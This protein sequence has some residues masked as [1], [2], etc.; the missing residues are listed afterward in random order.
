MKAPT[1]RDYEER[2]IHLSR[3]PQP[4]RILEG[5]IDPDSDPL[6]GVR[7]GVMATLIAS[8]ADLEHIQQGRLCA[9]CAALGLGIRGAT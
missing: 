1:L 6:C 5:R 3:G 4:P 9:I 2:P 8:V 7:G